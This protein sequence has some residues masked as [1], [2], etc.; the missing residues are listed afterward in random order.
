MLAT[1]LGAVLCLPQTCKDG[2][3]APK[4]REQCNGTLISSNW[5]NLGGGISGVS[6]DNIFYVSARALPEHWALVQHWCSIEGG[7]PGA[8]GANI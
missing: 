8:E 6:G 5:Q 1:R 7:T 4:T 3:R 2:F